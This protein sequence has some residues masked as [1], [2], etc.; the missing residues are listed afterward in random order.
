[1]VLGLVKK[2]QVGYY[3][4]KIIIVPICSTT[5]LGTM[6]ITSTIKNLI[7]AHLDPRSRCYYY[8]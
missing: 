7:T 6:P 4:F 8:K 1:M 5:V 2:Y 3:F